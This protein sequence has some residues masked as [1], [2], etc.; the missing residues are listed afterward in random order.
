MLRILTFRKTFGFALNPALRNK[1][2]STK[3]AIPKA[4]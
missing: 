2:L 4:L 3:P 1:R